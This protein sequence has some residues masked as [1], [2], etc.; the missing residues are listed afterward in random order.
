MGTVIAISTY[1][2]NMSAVQK[3][4]STNDPQSLT[5]SRMTRNKQVHLKLPEW[6]TVNIS[7][8]T[9]RFKHINFN[10]YI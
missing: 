5:S 10:E 9:K 1:L 8:E 7:P 6:H 3:D 2:G 4:L